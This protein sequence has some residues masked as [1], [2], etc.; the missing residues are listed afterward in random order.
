MINAAQLGARLRDARERRGLSQQVVADALG[1]PRTAVTNMEAGQRAVSTLE[2]TKLADLYARPVAWLLAQQSS[3]TDDLSIV[4]P[5]ALPEMQDAPEIGDAI[6]RM[7]DLFGDGAA[8]RGMLDD[9]IEQAVPNY[10]ARL[11]SAG[12]AIRQGEMLALEERRRL[13]L[14]SAP[15][16]NIAE[17]IATQG[18]W[19]AATDLPDSLSGL[20]LNHPSIGLAVIV[21]VRHSLVRKRF[22]YAHE[23]AHALLD[24]SETVTTTRREN[25][26]HLIEKRANAFAAAF[27][28]PPEGVAEVLRQLNKGL[29]SRHGQTL[30]DVANDRGMDAEIRPRPGSQVITYQDVAVL[31]RHYGL[32]YEATAWRLKSLNHISSLECNALI[33]RKEIGNRYIRLLGFS[34]LLDDTMSSTAPEQELRSQLTRLATEAYRREEISRERLLELGQKLGFEKG[35]LLVFANAARADQLEVDL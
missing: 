19:S 22:S 34:D 9:T 16:G 18:I 10:A 33:A 21:N 32:S 8:L 11:A 17:M 27:L 6:R 30:F 3:A 13:G 4:L 24:R 25:A 28:M 29:P 20:F 7:L 14:G 31:A 15:I 2:L 12:E 35:E 23:Y 1:L 5:R 26:T